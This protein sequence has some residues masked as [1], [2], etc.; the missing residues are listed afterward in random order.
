MHYEFSYFL[1]VVH[2][3][4]LYHALS[5]VVSN[6]SC[7]K[8]VE[9]ISNLSWDYSYSETGVLLKN[10]LSFF[11]IMGMQIIVYLTN[12]YFLKSISKVE[13]RF[14]NQC[15]RLKLYRS[16][17]S[18]T[19]VFYDNVQYHKHINWLQIDA[20]IDSCSNK[21]MQNYNYSIW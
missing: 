17:L 10:L 18:I 16:K 20:G 19:A 14:T 15:F 6:R 5:I 12:L 7:Y 1:C 2:Y 8:S 9:S 3:L 21:T 11:G 4:S 13:N